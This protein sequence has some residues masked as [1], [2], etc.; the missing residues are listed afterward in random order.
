M[1]SFVILCVGRVGSEHLVSLLDSHPDITCFSELFAPAW[2]VEYQGGTLSVPHFAE[3]AHEHP[4]GYWQE[5]TKG[6]AT[7]VNGLKLPGSSIDAHPD[8]AEL[9]ANPEVRIIR[10]TRRNRLAQYVSVYLALDSGVWHS[11][12]GGYGKDKIR[13]NVRDCLAGLDQIAQQEAALDELARGRNVFELAYEE[14]VRG[15]RMDELQAF[16]GVRP[17]KL[18]SRYERLRARPIS[19]VIENL[20]ELTAAL[21]GTPY[22]AD[23]SETAQ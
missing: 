2:A 16:L 6:L 23:L 13:V 7:P 21:A 9:I 19:E 15:Q 22:A 1:P 18:A 10:L 8:A 4:L 12:Q 3:T 5:L 20:D 11:T 14:L 17:R